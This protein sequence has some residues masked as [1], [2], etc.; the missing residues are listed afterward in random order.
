MSNPNQ[1]ENQPWYLN[2]M[3][4]MVIALPTTA[5]VAGLL[6]VYIAVTNQD[7]L[8]VDDYY[9]K[10]KAI[11]Q[12]LSRDRRATELGLSTLVDINAGTGEVLVSLSANEGFKS[13]PEITFKLIHRTL[14]GADQTTTLNRFED[15]QKDTIDYRG[16]IKPPVI[17]GRWTVQIIDDKN[18]RLKQNFK[19]KSAQHILLNVTS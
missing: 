12:E 15:K 11:N 19:T 5:V 4:W 7:S 13:S 10:G 6:T 16:Y 14:S 3:V 18:W 1:V 17:E 9:K 8:V 2:P